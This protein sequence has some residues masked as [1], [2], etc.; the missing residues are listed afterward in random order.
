MLSVL[1]IYMF[2]GDGL[3]AGSHVIISLVSQPQRLGLAGGAVGEVRAARRRDCTEY[4]R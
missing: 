2:F 3:I 4:R 1:R